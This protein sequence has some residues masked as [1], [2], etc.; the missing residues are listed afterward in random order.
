MLCADFHAGFACRNN[1]FQL[2]KQKVLLVETNGFP[3]G[4]SQFLLLKLSVFPQFAKVAK[5]N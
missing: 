3:K 2:L 5:T 1:S 4:N